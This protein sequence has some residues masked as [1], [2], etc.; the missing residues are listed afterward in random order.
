M[1]WQSSLPHLHFPPGHFPSR[2]WC[3]PPF[4]CS[5]CPFQNEHGSGSKLSSPPTCCQLRVRT[6]SPG[7]SQPCVP[8]S[9][10]LR[11][12]SWLSSHGKWTHLIECTRAESLLLL[13]PTGAAQKELER[14]WVR[15][16][17]RNLVL[18]RAFFSFKSTKFELKIFR[19]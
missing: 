3:S 6:S 19:E 2:S 12:L 7:D 13:L 14:P 10:E 5:V 18:T 4:P 1:F 15:I 16:Q 11:G 8:S 17:I 9:G